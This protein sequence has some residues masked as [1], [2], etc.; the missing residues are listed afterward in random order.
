VQTGDVFLITAADSQWLALVQTGHFA[1][2]GLIYFFSELHMKYLPKRFRE[3]CKYWLARGHIR[4]GSPLIFEMTNHAREWDEHCAEKSC[5]EDY[6]KHW[7]WPAQ[8]DPFPPP[9]SARP[10][11]K[12][13]GARLTTLDS[14]FA[15]EWTKGFYGNHT[16][17]AVRANKARRDRDFWN[18]FFSY[19]HKK[20]DTKY[21]NGSGYLKLFCSILC[22]N[23]STNRRKLFCSEFTALFHKSIKL[24]ECN[25]TQVLPSDYGHRKGLCALQ[26]ICCC[27]AYAYDAR[28][29][30]Y[31]KFSKENIL[32]E[33][34][35]PL[36]ILDNT[37]IK[38][39]IRKE[40]EQEKVLAESRSGSAP[41]TTVNSPRLDV[42]GISL[43][44]EESLSLDTELVCVPLSRKVSSSGEVLRSRHC[45][46][47]EDIERMSPT[48]GKI[49]H[50]YPM[51]QRN[52]FAY[53]EEDSHSE[54]LYKARSEPIGMADMQT[55]VLEIESTI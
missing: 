34:D 37:S 44:F 38:P 19:M 29:F 2:S 52:G 14:Y 17:I 50:A 41:G 6:P 42:D 30:R 4:E 46:I 21:S 54:Y 28:T 23:F 40:R 24:I 3:Q 47:T 43:R 5:A 36:Y 55:R 53:A 27:F 7:R 48:I 18:K 20:V 1:H 45:S 13:G 12:N 33:E 31:Y 26:Y 8:T 49:K 39:Y 35:C 51:H 11:Y 16:L 9:D 32:D 22:P 10:K 25:P 15:N